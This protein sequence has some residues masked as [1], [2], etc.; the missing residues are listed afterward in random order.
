MLKKGKFLS[1]IVTALV[2]S[3]TLGAANVQAATVKRTDGTRAAPKVTD[4]KC[5]APGK[6]G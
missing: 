5:Y 6:A 3:V 4:S 1:P 2:L